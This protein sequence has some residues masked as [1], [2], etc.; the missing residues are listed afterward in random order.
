MANVYTC[1][2][3]LAIDLFIEVAQLKPNVVNRSIDDDIQANGK[4]V[5]VSL[6]LK[7]SG[8]QILHWALAEDL[9]GLILRNA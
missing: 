9:L 6:I 4:G 2:M 8:Y 1:T 3:N 7:N 5:N